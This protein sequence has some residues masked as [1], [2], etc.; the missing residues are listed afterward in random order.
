MIL[1]NK[2]G[3][4]AQDGQFS[5]PVNQPPYS[6]RAELDAILSV[7]KESE[8]A[9]EKLRKQEENMEQDVTQKAKDL[10]EKEFKIPEPKPMPCLVKNNACIAC[11]KENANVLI[12]K[13]APLA[14][15]FADLCA[16]RVRQLA[17]SA[18]K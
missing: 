8:N 18:D 17:K 5:L 2:K 14:Q 11:Y 1:K 12:I 6:A 15:N 4:Q 16:R 7:V 9:V 3:P 10:Q 13:F